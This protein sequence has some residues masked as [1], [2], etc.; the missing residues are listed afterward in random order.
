MA[1]TTGTGAVPRGK[2]I[3]SREV[4]TLVL[5]RPGSTRHVRQ[6][7]SKRDLS[8]G[9]AE[10]VLSACA[11]GIR[12]SDIRA[13]RRHGSLRPCMATGRLASGREI[14]TIWDLLKGRYAVAAIR[15]PLPGPR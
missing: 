2:R 10:P 5:W 7:P 1:V 4:P 15:A 3:L 12:L 11:P 8:G 9:L 13:W 6:H 14:E